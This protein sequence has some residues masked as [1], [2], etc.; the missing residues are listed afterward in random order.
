MKKHLPIILFAATI[1]LGTVGYVMAEKPVYEALLNSIGL[2]VLNGDV[3]PTNVVIEI[4]RW[5]GIGF[6]LDVVYTLVESAVRASAEDVR[7]RIRS[8]KPG[9]TAVHG[10]GVYADRFAESLGE[11]GIRSDRA[12]AFDAPCQVLLFSDDAKAVSFFEQHRESL[13]SSGEVYM[14]LD[15]M[16]PDVAKHPNVF[17]F[18]MA[19]V[20][21]QLYWEDFPVD[22]AERIVL[23]GDGPYAE[24]LLTQALLVNLFDVSGGVRY[25]VFGEFARYRNLHPQ[26]ETAVCANGDSLEFAAEPWYEHINVFRNADRIVLCGRVENNLQIAADLQRTGVLAPLHI[27]CSS[28]EDLVLLQPG[29]EPRSLVAFGTTEQLCTSAIV[30]QQRQHDGG[31]VCDI[32]YTLGTSACDG[33]KRQAVGFPVGAMADAATDEERAVLKEAR[34]AAVDFETCLACPSFKGR[35][36]I[37]DEFTKQSNYAVAAH[38]IHRM[39]LLERAGAGR[40][41]RVS[42][43]DLPLQARDEMQEIE[44]IRWCRFHYLNNW[45]YAP[46]GKD[47]VDRTH[48]YLVPYGQLDRLTK[49][50]DADS[51]ATLWMRRK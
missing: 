19:Q 30:I 29:W 31:K 6:A 41:A 48:H 18:S 36:R 2:A 16:V 1:V 10:D 32:A 46:G 24:A 44:H 40:D 51:Y 43:F 50:L 35:W 14:A 15:S 38:D 13:L 21:A 49:D 37:M 26:L 23:I 25:E 39:K 11:L 42:F 28:A 4:A 3:E 47:K 5:C 12:A 8:R 22:R 33:C 27:R 7:T 45:S 34:L 17:T 9:A 20:C